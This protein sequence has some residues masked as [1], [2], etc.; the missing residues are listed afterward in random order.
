MDPSQRISQPIYAGRT[1]RRGSIGSTNREDASNGN[2]N[3]APFNSFRPGGDAHHNDLLKTIYVSNIT[4]SMPDD[5]L[6]E[7]FGQ[8]GRIESLVRRDVNVDMNNNSEQQYAFIRFRN[9]QEAR[10]AITTGEINFYGRKL[11]IRARDKPSYVKPNGHTHDRPR[12]YDGFDRRQR[13]QIDRRYDSRPPPLDTV[14]VLQIPPAQAQ[15]TLN[16]TPAETLS[17]ILTVANLPADMSPKELYDLFASYG[18]VERSY[19][20]QQADSAGRVPLDVSYKI[21][22]PA[23]S[24]TAPEPVSPITPRNYA[25]ALPPMHWP[26]HLYGANGP[27][28]QGGHNSAQYPQQQSGI[29]VPYA[30]WNH[31][32]N[33][34]SP[35]V[36]YGFPPVPLPGLPPSAH[37]IPV[38]VYPQ[39]VSGGQYQRAFPAGSSHF[40]QKHVRQNAA[41]EMMPHSFAVEPTSRSV[42]GASSATLVAEN[43]PEYIRDRKYEP[44]VIVSS[45]VYREEPIKLCLPELKLSDAAAIGNMPSV[46]TD[47]CPKEQ[48]PASASTTSPS[49]EAPVPD[50]VAPTV[51]AFDPTQPAFVPETS[52]PRDPCNLFVKNL[53]DACIATT[54][55]LKAK[56]G[57][58]GQVASAYLATYP[59]GASKC[60][61]FVSFVNPADAAHAKNALHGGMLGRK[62]LFVTFAE[63]KD[64]RSQ[65]LKELF[66]GKKPEGTDDSCTSELKD[67]TPTNAAMEI[68]PV[69]PM[70]KA[71]EES[72]KISADITEISPTEVSDAAT[73]PTEGEVTVTTTVTTTKAWKG[74]QLHGI[75]EVEEEES[76]CNK[77]YRQ[78]RAHSYMQQQQPGGFAFK[79]SRPLQ[80]PHSISPSSVKTVSP[81]HHQNHHHHSPQS[82]GGRNE[83]LSGSPT[84]RQRFPSNEIGSQQPAQSPRNGQRPFYPPGR[85]GSSSPKASGRRPDN[86]SVSPTPMPGIPMGPRTHVNRSG[87]NGNR[88]F[89]QKKKKLGRRGSGSSSPIGPE[90]ERDHYY[91][92]ECHLDT[93]RAPDSKPLNS[94][95]SSDLKISA[96][97][98][99]LESHSEN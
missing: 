10:Y 20:Y 93:S 27:Q 37:T 82:L 68:R 98:E 96:H 88:D 43:N 42:S 14:P 58:Y 51:K 16:P 5:S 94:D 38:C 66:E 65:R 49:P 39:Q 1:A 44:P 57:L 6:W 83:G 18:V 78:Q 25:W 67:E 69:S 60:Y 87:N 89:V 17:K 11:V 55:D 62:R 74:T 46:S 13:Q 91:Q 24:T 73:Q 21:N 47:Y 41:G 71:T 63:R 81:Y 33:T 61:G 75:V 77:K 15:N 97:G 35:S 56:F 53:D 80:L 2:G 90:Q 9:R 26:Y 92:S 7:A 34:G 4:S 30:V 8:F 79:D 48:Q 22:T 76:P 29:V 32:A 36:N 59:N 54:M 84:Q 85:G 72:K 3:G 70:N 45:P 31:G 86:M 19:I 40:G 23:V 52:R 64:E 50:T 28:L 95:G 99:A 12:D